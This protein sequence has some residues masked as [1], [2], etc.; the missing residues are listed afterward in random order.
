MTQCTSDL[1]NVILDGKFRGLP[2]PYTPKQYQ[3]PSHSQRSF[4]FQWLCKGSSLHIPIWEIP[5]NLWE[6]PWVAPLHL[7]LCSAWQCRWHFSHSHE[8]NLHWI[9]QLSVYSWDELRFYIPMY[10]K[11]RSFQRCSS[12]PISW[13]V[14]RKQLHTKYTDIHELSWCLKAK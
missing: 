13:L 6:F 7:K 3:V 1:D 5:W 10:T 9:A 2:F 4:A 12:Q 8:K 11:Y 14:L